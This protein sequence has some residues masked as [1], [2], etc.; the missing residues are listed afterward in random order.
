MVSMFE[1]IQQSVQFIQKATNEFCPEAGIILGSGL[2]GL[3]K[4]VSVEYEL[5][6]DDIPGFVKPTVEMHGGSLVFGK[7]GKKAVVCMK[8]RFHYYEGYSLQQITFPVR[9][10]KAL[11]AEMLIVSNAAGA[12]NPHY[13]PGTIM[14]ITDHINLLGTNPLIGANDER[15]GPRWPDMYQAYDAVLLEQMEK[16]ALSKSIPLEKGVY[17]CMS[18]PSMETA[19]EYRMLRVIG[20]DA[21]GMSTVPEV[22]VARHCG[23]RVAG[24]SVLTDACLPDAMEPIDISRIIGHAMAAEPHMIEII[25][26][27]LQEAS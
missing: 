11:G 25:K 14:A 15:L 1:Q 12:L 21:I 20:A 6:Y 16:G 19:A 23:L 5:P 2:A 7:I 18:G 27:I 26:S 8:G 10:I 22:I 3:E 17:A 9:V 24:L 13:K 4:H